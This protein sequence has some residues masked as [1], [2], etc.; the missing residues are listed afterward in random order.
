ME[1]AIMAHF[2]ATRY[3]PKICSLPCQKFPKAVCDRTVHV[4]PSR[5]QLL[6]WAWRI[7]MLFR[8]M[9]LSLQW[10]NKVLQTSTAS[11]SQMKIMHL[12]CQDDTAKSY[13]QI[14]QPF[15]FELPIVVWQK[16][17][18]YLSCSYDP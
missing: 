17:A 2:G 14:C 5:W 9:I 4:T 16:H 15:L 11:P 7:C 1:L 8:L 13:P 18:L 12:I 6:I 3:Q 10:D